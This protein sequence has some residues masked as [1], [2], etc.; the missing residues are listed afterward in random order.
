MPIKTIF[1][2]RDGVINKD[3]NYLY[4][5]DDFD[6][7]KGIF[8]A[9][10]YFQSLEYKIIIITNQSGISRGYFT[11][12]D[13]EILNQWMLDSFNEKGIKI[14]GDLPIYVAPDSSDAW[15][16]PELFQIDPETR[17]F[18]HVAGVPPDYF[19]SDGQYWGNP[20]YN[21]EAH[22]ADNYEWWM[23]R[24]DSQ[25]K[26]FDVVRIDHFRG[27][28][29]FWSIPVE[30]SDAKLGNWKEGPGVDFWNVAQK[31]FPTLPF[32]AE[33]LGLITNG[34]RKLR[35][36]AG[37]PGMAVLQFA[38]DGD[39]ENLY[40]PHNLTPDLVLYTGTHD[41][42]TT[43][44]WYHSCKEEVRGNFRTYFNIPGDFPSWDMLRMAYRTTAQLVIIP[45]QDLLSLGSEARL[46]E[47][48]YPFGNWTWRM[49]P[50]ELAK[51]TTECT[52]YL[53]DQA[54][55]CGRMKIE[56]ALVSK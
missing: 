29:D 6:F 53:R 8:D 46:N 47:P 49:K 52:H 23:R 40:L 45:M 32:L 33:D 20:L 48:G 28:H 55:V 44:G 1:L 12:R 7:I 17:Q 30:T 13:Y 37:L 36:D 31:R 5:I 21:R 24:L 34:V 2:D 15:E 11:E 9:C 14:I 56:K 10:F 43:C 26:L 54:K 16:R 39:P 35:H 41:N 3:T 27:F 19:N 42:D 50:W 25:L 18:S 51:V 22:Q 38:F 4:K